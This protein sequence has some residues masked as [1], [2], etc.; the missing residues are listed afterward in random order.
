METHG[1]FITPKAIYIRQ[2]ERAMRGYA[3]MGVY[4][5]EYPSGAQ[6]GVWD[7]DNLRKNHVTNT[8]V[9]MLKDKAETIFFFYSLRYM[10][11]YC[12]YNLVMLSCFVV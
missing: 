11:N 5:C 8:T 2:T 4:V 10:C 12:C 3:I 6:T 1:D 7:G 9:G